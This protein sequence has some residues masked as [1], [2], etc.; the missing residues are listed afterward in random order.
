MTLEAPP[1]E[2][3]WFRIHFRK[4]MIVVRGVAELERIKARKVPKV[5]LVEPAQIHECSVCHKR[6][7]WGATW[8]WYG[9]WRAIDEGRPV[10][11]FCSSDCRKRWR[12]EPPRR[13]GFW[14]NGYRPE[15]ERSEGWRRLHEAKT[16]ANVRKFPAPAHPPERTG[17][18]WCRWCGEKVTEKG[19]R[20]WHAKCLQLHWLHTDRDAQYRFLIARDGERCQL[21]PSGT[22][23]WVD[24]GPMPSWMG[25]GNRIQWSEILEVDHIIP[26]WSGDEWP[27]P[28]ERRALFGP[29]NLWLLCRRHHRW[30]SA[31]EAADRAAGKKPD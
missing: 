23:R 5:I 27:D 11:K 21:C 28:A 20:T 22:G 19:R 3:A 2:E 1:E 6:E 29:D 4:T 18:G 16:A 25:V 26:L 7:A 10:R 24:A 17:N 13:K 31:K 14:L 15:D 9:S 30:K 8:Q 12:A